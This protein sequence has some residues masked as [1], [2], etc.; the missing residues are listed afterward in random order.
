[1]DLEHVDVGAE[2]FDALLDRVED[3]LAAEADLVDHVAVIGGYA[4]D[5]QA[6]VFLD[7]AEVAFGEENDFVARDVVLLQRLC[8]D[9]LR[10]AVGVDISLSRVSSADSTAL[11]A[12][13]WYEAKSCVG[14][15][16]P[17]C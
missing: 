5:A 9:L 4:G 3:V 6:R 17:R 14:L 7:D 8:D 10:M 13:R 1:M 12:P 15:P 11:P 16:Y 2:A